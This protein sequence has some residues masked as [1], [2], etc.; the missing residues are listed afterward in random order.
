[1]FGCDERHEV[2]NAK[3]LAFEWLVL[4][5]VGEFEGARKS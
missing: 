1:M 4:A 5:L 2:K 3:S